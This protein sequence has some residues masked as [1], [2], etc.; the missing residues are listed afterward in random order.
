MLITVNNLFDLKFELNEY[1]VDSNIKLIGDRIFITKK[2][3]SL[4]LGE[5]I[6]FRA[7]KFDE[8][9]SIPTEKEVKR[10]YWSDKNFNYYGRYN[11]YLFIEELYTTHI[12]GWFLMGASTEKNYRYVYTMSNRTIIKFIKYI[13][14]LY[15]NSKLSRGL[16]IKNLLNG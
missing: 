12:D 5:P 13:F 14:N 2:L 10:T 11:I 3:C 1:Y 4:I 9:D 6:E 7:A 8:M 16:K 15:V